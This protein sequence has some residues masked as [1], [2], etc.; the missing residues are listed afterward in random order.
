MASWNYTVKA[1]GKVID[2]ITMST[3]SGKPD[4]DSAP[5]FSALSISYGLGISS[6]MG[7]VTIGEGRLIHKALKET[8]L[9]SAEN[10]RTVS[11]IEL[12][13]LDRATVTASDNAPTVFRLTA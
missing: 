9:I 12:S 5:S 8:V 3:S 10:I 1:D 2:T 13:L 4:P 6:R 7:K 11:K